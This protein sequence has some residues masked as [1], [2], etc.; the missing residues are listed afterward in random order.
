MRLG[1][2]RLVY[3]IFAKPLTL[4][5]QRK[6]LTCYLPRAARRLIVIIKASQRIMIS[7]MN[8]RG[9]YNKLAIN[10]GNQCEAAIT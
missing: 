9:Q 3:G 6:S 5:H 2:W 4:F 8:V 10:R 7:V 1:E